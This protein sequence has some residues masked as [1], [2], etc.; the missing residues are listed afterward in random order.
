MSSNATAIVSDFSDKKTKF[1]Q[2]LEKLVGDTIK[3][4]ALRAIEILTDL[5]P[6]G[7]PIDTT[8]AS[9]NWRVTQNNFVLEKVESDPVNAGDIERSWNKQ[10][11]Q[12]NELREAKVRPEDTV[13]LVNN[14]PYIRRLNEEQHSKQ[15]PKYFVQTAV[16]KAQKEVE[17]EMKKKIKKK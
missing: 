8:W 3:E 9:S 15:S 2:Q 5:P 13:Y 1:Y 14:T 17:R 6:E 7:T 16:K 10:Q 11:Q 12:I 4:T